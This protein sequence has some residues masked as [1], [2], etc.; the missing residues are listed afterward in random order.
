MANPTGPGGL[1]FSRMLDGSAMH[2][3]IH[4]Y[5]V[6]A[7]SAAIGFGSPVVKLAGGNSAA[8]ANGIDRYEIGTL[9]TA[10]AYVPGSASAIT[11][12]VTG[13]DPLAV[14][15]GIAVIGAS[16][17]VNTR[18]VSVIDSSKAAFLV[19][20]DG[21]ITLTAAAIGKGAF[22]IAGA[23]ISSGTAQATMMLDTGGTNALVTSGTTA[24][25]VILRGVPNSDN[26]IGGPNALWEVR[27][28]NHTEAEGVGAAAV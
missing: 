16:P 5:V 23:A 25:C 8:I 3:G 12:V 28:L 6:D 27:I 2:A 14:S 4:K 10:T 7:S 19:R 9:E 21:L 24:N 26:V 11:G 15:P 1:T 18:V 22:F 20:D 13:I 17:T